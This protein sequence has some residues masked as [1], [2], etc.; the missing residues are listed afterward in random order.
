MDEWLILK[1]AGELQRQRA[2]YASSLSEDEWLKNA[3]ECIRQT[4]FAA[5]ANGAGILLASPS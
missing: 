3:F 2:S 1:I 4:A 5:S